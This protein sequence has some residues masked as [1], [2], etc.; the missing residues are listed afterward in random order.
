MSVPF[1]RGI[2][3]AMATP[4]RDGG[5]E[6]DLVRARRHAAELVARGS[7]GIL[8][9]GSGGEF[10]AMTP[11]ERKCLAEAVIDELRGHAPVNVCIAAYT[12]DV[13]I[14]LGRHARA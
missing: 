3:A 6:V 11:E 13:A 7:H 14:D 4:F 9:A 5:G 2:F 10:I 12:T 8:V 1:P